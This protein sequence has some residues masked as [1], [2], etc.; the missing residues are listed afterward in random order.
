M[1]VHPRVD[2]VTVGAGWTAGVLAWKLTAEGQQVVSLEAGRERWTTP[3]FDHN[4]DSLRYM[5]RKAMMYDLSRETWTWRPNA[6]APSLPMRQYGSFHPGEGLGGAGIHWAAQSW[7]FNPTDFRYRSHHVEKYGEAKLPVNNRLQDWPITYDELEPYYDQVEYDIGIA[8]L[9]GNLHGQRVPGGDPFEG[10]RSR[11]YPLPPLVSSIPAQ[12]FHE[13]A[14]RLGYHPFPQPASILPE[15]YSG[16]STT[17][18]AGCLY[19]GFC[20]RYGCEVDAKASVINT[21]M[22]HALA[23]GRYEIRMHSKVTRINIGADGLATGVTYID[24]ETGEE[25]EQ[26]ADLVL[27]TA[28]TLSNVRLLLLSQSDAHPNGVGNDRGLVGKNYTYQLVQTPVTG[29]FEGRRFNRFMGNSCLR[30]VMNDFNSDNFDH[31]DLD[32]IGGAYFQAGGGEMQP[33]TSTL[34]MPVVDMEANGSEGDEDGNG[35]QGL[36][37]RP[38]IAGEVGSLAGSGTEWGQDWKENLRQNWDSVVEIGI[39]GESLAFEGNELDLD[40][41]FTDQFGLP[42]LR[43]TYDFRENDYNMYRFLAQRCREIMDEMGPARSSFTPELTPYDLHSYQSTHNTGGAIMGDSP[44]SS[45][46]NKYGQVWD[47][48]NVFVTGAALY[49]QNP[50]YN[51]TET[52]LALAYLTGEALVEDYLSDPNRLLG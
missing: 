48:L 49:P 21:H 17:P 6:D 32:F 18:R 15:A 10:P 11:P 45:V 4:H 52:A 14:T 27:V 26:P 2:V 8:G 47:T 5:T 35:N 51:P 13:A 39:H 37:K 22:P 12:M 24:L 36:R 20:T 43:I 34:N 40:P 41:V 7:R 1:A 19:C 29:V 30:N 3:D 16:I 25:H 31:S 46:T 9:A 38:A 50:G 44:D 23:T 42:L 28:Y 33:V